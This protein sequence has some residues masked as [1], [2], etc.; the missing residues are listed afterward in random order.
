MQPN[1]DK[2]A[3][4]QPL[5]YLAVMPAERHPIARLH[6]AIAVVLLSFCTPYANV[7]SSAVD[8]LYWLVPASEHVLLKLIPISARLMKDIIKDILQTF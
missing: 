5:H 2:A 6:S 8:G 7:S 4:P 3:H 1:T